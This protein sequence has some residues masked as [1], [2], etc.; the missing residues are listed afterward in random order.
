MATVLVL[1]SVLTPTDAWKK[2]KVGHR[3]LQVVDYQQL[4]VPDFSF[5]Q[6]ATACEQL[7]QQAPQPVVLIGEG[8]GSL[9]ALKIATTM[10]G[11]LDR[12]VLVAAQY[13][14][15]SGLL[16]GL[17]TNP[18]ISS[19]QK[20]TLS[21]SMKGLDMTKALVHIMCST[22]VY[23]GEKDRFSRQACEDIAMRLLDGH[24]KI[25][26]KMGR[27]INEDGLHAISENLR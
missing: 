18:T 2:L 22:Y 10:F 7:A 16:V 27:Q 24:L 25:V 23:C 8:V 15:R 12:L 3:N 4:D 1:P 19:Q 14:N 21:R 26:P 11:R 20:R 9:L 5:D 17:F 13:K 6:L